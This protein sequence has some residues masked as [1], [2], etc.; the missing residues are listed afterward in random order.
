VLQISPGQ[1]RV[2]SA[3]ECLSVRHFYISSLR[4]DARKKKNKASD[5]EVPW[6]EFCP[7][8]FLNFC[9]GAEILN[10]AVFSLIFYARKK[11]ISALDRVIPISKIFLTRFLKFCLGA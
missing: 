8:D 10:F 6:V 9:L 4:F 5:R 11:I 7:P 2:P 1:R 3:C